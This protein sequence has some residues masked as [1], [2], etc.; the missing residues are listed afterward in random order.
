MV[1]DLRVLSTGK[2]S[3]GHRRQLRSTRRSR[4]GFQKTFRRKVTFESLERRDLLTGWADGSPLDSLVSGG[5]GEMAATDVVRYRLELTDTANQPLPTDANGNPRVSVGETFRLH[6]YTQDVRLRTDPPAGSFAWGNP[7]GV[8]ASYIDVFYT[9]A[10]RLMVRHGETQQLEFYSSN[11]STKISGQFTLAFDG[12]T[13]AS[14]TYDPL[15]DL[16][17]LASAVQQALEGLPNIGSG[18]VRVSVAPTAQDADPLA[19][20]DAVRVQFANALGERDVPMIAINSAQLVGLQQAVA[21][22]LY[23]ADLTD[24]GTFRSSFTAVA[25][26]VHGLKAVDKTE[27]EFGQPAGGRSFGSVGSFFNEFQNDNERAEFE[28]F[29][30]DLKAVAGGQV[31]FSG[32]VPNYSEAGYEGT[33]TLVFPSSSTDPKFIVEPEYI[34]FAQDIANPLTLTILPPPM[35]DIAGRAGGDGSWWV[36]ESTG[37]QFASSPWGAWPTLI[38][39][40]DVLVGDFNGDGRADLVGRNEG[41]WW[42]TRSTG[43]G[44]V[45]EPWGTWSTAVTWEDVLV[46]D[47]NGD[48]LDDL[49]GRANGYWWLAKS[50]GTSFVNERWD[51]WTVAA[52]WLDVQAAD[53]NGDGRE[54]LVGRLSSTGDWTVARSTGT[55]FVSEKWGK[56][57]TAINW[58]SVKA[59]DFNADGRTDVVGRNSA[60]GDWF[61]AR[62]TGTGFVTE[63]WGTWSSSVA[64]QNIHVGDVNGDARD[65]IV[66]R[67]GG[68]LWVARSTGTGFVSER[69]ATGTTAGTWQDVQVGDLNGDG[70]DDYAGRIGGAWWLASSTGS[71]FSI[72]SWTQWPADGQWQ[73]L[74]LGDVNADGAVDLLG[75]TEGTWWVARQSEGSVISE[76]RTQWPHFV[77]WQDVQAA[78]VDGDGLDDIVGRKNGV[79]WVARSTGSGFVTEPWG[80]W[81]TAVTWEDVLAGDFNGDG[82]ADLAGRANGYWW[83]AKSTGT[84]FVNERWDRWTTSAAWLD[85]QIADVDGDG[86]DDLVG[87]L[88]STGDWVVARSTGTSF[89]SG[90]WGK[91]STA[92]NWTN[93]TAGDFNGDGRWDLVGRN[94]ANGDWLVA[95]STG[96]AFAT[97]KWG[98]WSTSVSWRDIRVG[99]VTGDGRADIVGRNGG[100]WW[101]ARSTGTGFV[102]SRWVAGTSAATWQEV[103]LAD[104]TG[105]GT[106]DVVGRADNVWWVAQSTGT[107]FVVQPWGTWPAGITW[108]D[109]LVGNF[110]HATPAA[111]HA[112]GLPAADAT[113]VPAATEG[114]VQWLAES[115]VTRLTAVAGMDE[116]GGESLPLLTFQIADLPGTLLGQSLGHTILI[117][118]DAAGFGWFVDLTPWDDVEFTGFTGGG[119]LIAMPGGAADG[120]MDLLT[121]V[122]HELGH[123]LGYDHSDIG[124]MQPTLAAGVRRLFDAHEPADD[125]GGLADLD[126]YFAALG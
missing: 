76:P 30:V 56:W 53:V 16:K 52:A 109:V 113:P 63:K 32:N 105:D 92:I 117:D 100:D 24:P 50:T 7:K 20:P 33:E 9:N 119:D 48:G 81:S 87:R 13:T 3:P 5:E 125:E 85:V 46:G 42:V 8:F 31:A 21:I 124:L 26:Y 90:T 123:L 79:W 35:A 4:S 39:W 17:D 94:S 55:S 108:Q 86:L 112:A 111:L 40:Q 49:A 2:C 70:K 65:D 43:N 95:R 98:T 122:M 80:K 97:E 1:A 103:Q 25:P 41:A 118:R 91:W 89:V 10:D 60:T 22:E 23:P 120:R 66:G 126:A 47:F 69:W 11:P 84:S 96:T 71:G 77:Q 73:D 110:S 38:D 72:S 37:S 82:L 51:R 106:E 14:I 57:S 12:R 62:S 99:D 27:L 116:A 121:V 67:N 75:R 88:S 64:W 29:S 59:A 34:G 44:F 74:R 45:N 15:W 18:N 93:V 19:T 28:F 61:V 102:T 101:V 78:D 58:T 54:D 104:V 68:D 114:A 107:A 36:G 115:V 83:L 6:G